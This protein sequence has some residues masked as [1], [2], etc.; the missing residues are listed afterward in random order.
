MCENELMHGGNRDRRF[1]VGVVVVGLAVWLLYCAVQPHNFWSSSNSGNARATLFGWDAP[2]SADASS[3]PDRI[4]IVL[5][6]WTLL[7]FTAGWLRPQRWLTI[8]ACAVLPT[9]VIYVPTAPRDMDA[10][11]ATGPPGRPITGISP[12]WRCGSPE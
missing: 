10:Q 5:L 1:V 11:V 6:G 2:G 8:G 12:V 9:W 3:V 7:S 4:W